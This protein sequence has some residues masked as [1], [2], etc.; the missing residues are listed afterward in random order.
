MSLS[1]LNFKNGERIDCDKFD[2][3]VQ[4]SVLRKEAITSDPLGLI[5][6]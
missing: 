3:Y 6:H 5:K 4:Q 2:V 1:I